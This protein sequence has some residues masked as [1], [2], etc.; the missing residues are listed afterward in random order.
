MSTKAKPKEVVDLGT[1]EEGLFTEADLQ[2]N[3]ATKRKKKAFLKA[4]RSTLGVITPA[5][6]K[7]GI[8]SVKTIYIWK[9]KDEAFR[10]LMMEQK[11]NA[12]DFAESS[13]FGQIRDKNPMSTMYYLR[14]QGRHRGWA[15]TTT[16]INVNKDA[17]DLEGLSDEELVAIIKGEGL[18]KD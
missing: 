16:N 6:T 15:E 14:T 1:K 2:G 3:G 10:T 12:L 11:D 17:N 4:L 8:K 13:L 9:E 5:A 18:M 7:V